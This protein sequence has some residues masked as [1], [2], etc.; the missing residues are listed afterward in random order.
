MISQSYIFFL[1]FTARQRRFPIINKGILL[2]GDPLSNQPT[3]GSPLN[4]TCRVYNVN[5][6]FWTKNGLVFPPSRNPSSNS[7]DLRI[8]ANKR[9]MGKKDFTMQLVFTRVKQ[10]DRGNYSCV[11][12]DT[13]FGHN[14]HSYKYLRPQP[15][16]TLYLFMKTNLLL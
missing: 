4:M 10:E 6:V 12:R 5:H 9:N 16:G 7:T 14:V 1:L 2:N 15:K 11:G 3:I 8:S 13:F